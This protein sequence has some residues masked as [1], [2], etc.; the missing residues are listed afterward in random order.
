[1]PKPRFSLKTRFVFG[2]GLMLLPLLVVIGV[3]FSAMDHLSGILDRLA[4]ESVA[5]IGPVSELQERLRQ[6]EDAM[7]QERVHRERATVASLTPLI[8]QAYD[9]I[10]SSNPFSQREEKNAVLGSRH[11]WR[12]VVNLWN[13]G[14]GGTVEID[15]QLHLAEQLLGQARNIALNEINLLHTRQ[16]NSRWAADILLGAVLLLGVG[17][18]VLI[19]VV[20]SRAVLGPVRELEAGV[21]QFGDG[22]L[23]ARVAELSQDELG[24]LARTFNQMARKLEQNHQELASLS[25][26]DFLTGLH[27]VRE[28]Y[29]LFHDETRRVDRYGHCFSLLLIDIDRFKE[30]NDTFGHQLGDY[31]LQEVARKLGELIRASDHAARIGGDEFAVLLSETDMDDARDFGERIRGYFAGHAIAQVDHP[32]EEIRISVS[33]GLASYPETARNANELFAAADAALYRAK[34]G[35]RNLLCQ[36]GL[37][38]DPDS[39]SEG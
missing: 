27:N 36:A 3:S 22:E 8:D 28:F 37:N 34:Q 17:L 4:K 21:R 2:L 26:V 5:E 7:R 10:I 35:G 9:K 33:I 30:I 39:R 31:V 11:A 6:V 14:A 18:S 12:Q 23:S 15:K 32:D 19:G 38:A 1:M 25:T 24:D 29:R 16:R 13:Q 20:F